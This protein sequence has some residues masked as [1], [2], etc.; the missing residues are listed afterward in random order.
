VAHILATHE[1][2]PLGEDVERELE[3]IRIRA[4]DW[5]ND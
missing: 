4:Q 5:D 3:H 2:L 1:P